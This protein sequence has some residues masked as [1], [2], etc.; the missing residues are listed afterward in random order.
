[1]PPNVNPDRE[2]TI[3]SI[4]DTQYYVEQDNGIFPQMTQWIADNKDTY[5]IETFW[6]GGDIVQ[7]FNEVPSEWNRAETAI[8]TITD[9]GITPLLATGNHDIGTSSTRDRTLTEFHSRFGTSWYQQILDNDSSVTD[10]GTYEGDS[11]NLYIV[12]EYAGTEF[13]WIVSEYMPRDGVMD[14]VES[15]FDSNAEK[16]GGYLTHAYIDYND[17]F[18]TDT[19]YINVSDVNSGQSQWQNWIGNT[20]NVAFTM[21]GHYHDPS[22]FNGR[23]TDTTTEGKQITAQHHDYQSADA[24]GGDGWLRLLVVDTETGTLDGYTYSPFLD[25]WDSS[26]DTEYSITAWTPVFSDVLVQRYDGSSWTEVDARVKDS[27]VFSDVTIKS[28][29]D[30][31]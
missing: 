5:N 26:A 12:Q 28:V 15:T 13:V 20:G 23:R 22:D 27:G 9:E 21:N 1:M 8:E 6:H 14:W 29:T 11:E 30:I 17:N 16:I 31:E 10:W 18:G 25:S 4:N 3:A 2:F 19:D 24:N 7:N